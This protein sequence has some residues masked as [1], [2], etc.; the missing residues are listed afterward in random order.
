MK[1]VEKTRSLVFEVWVQP[2]ARRS[3]LV[4][5]QGEGLKIK[6]GAPPVQDRAN[7]EVVKFLSTLLGVPRSHVVILSGHRRRRKRVEIEGLSAA[8]F[9]KMLARYVV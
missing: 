2:N 4:G 6:V 9:R 3:E 7:Q 1:I 8:D 5:L